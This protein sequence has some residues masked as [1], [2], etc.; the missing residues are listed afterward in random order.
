M[1][2]DHQKQARTHFDRM[3]AAYE[4]IKSQRGIK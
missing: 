3:S 1:A 2:D 4:A